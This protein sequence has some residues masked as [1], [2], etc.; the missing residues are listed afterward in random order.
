MKTIYYNGIV[1]TGDMPP[2]SGFAVENGKFTAVGSDESLLK[3]RC[4][5]DILIDLQG[6]FVCAGFND[7]HMHLLNYGYALTMAPLHRHTRSLSDMLDCLRSFLAENP[8]RPGDYLLG[9]GWN[10]DYFEDEHRLPTKEDLDSVS[11]D[12]PI[13]I[14]RACGHIGCA[15]TAAI[16]M[17]GV[18][19]TTPQPD[20]GHFD[21]V[22]GELTGIFRE[23]ALSMVK[24]PIPQPDAE[25]IADMIRTAAKALN[26]YGIT[27]C[28]T[29]DFCVFPDVSPETIHAAY[30]RL[31]DADDLTVRVYE[32]AHFCD[33]ESLSRYI[34]AGHTTGEGDDFFRVGPLK[35]L[36]D[37]S[38]GAGTAYLS[39]PYADQPD[40]RGIAIY[41]PEQFHAM[42]SLA[43]NSDMQ[44]AIHAIGDGILDDILD[45]YEDV[46]TKNPRDDHRHG[47]VHCQI[48]RPDQLTRMKDLRLHAYVQSIFLDYDNRIVRQRV[49]DLADSSY[50]FRT[51]KEQYHASNGSDCPVELPNVLGGIQCGVTRNTLSGDALY[52]PEE[53]FSV[54]QAIDS[55]TCEGAF[56]SFEE[57][58]KG[59]IRPGMLADFVVL[60]TS[61]FDTPANKIADIPVLQTVLGGKCVYQK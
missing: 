60:G 3:T 53:A 24:A 2:V 40:N 57:N 12:V 25:A 27:S 10:H 19:P 37:G 34:A 32:Q 9:R 5:G 6:K 23:N 42:I 50:A 59:K 45:A 29:D 15:N 21:I 36:G 20:G 47:V 22:N 13:I 4:D 49:G 39:R 46:L 30:R 11:R 54:Q 28:Q 38:L 16:H 61:P 58:V 8:P 17:A 41:T 31:S 51:L 18:T 55:F 1:Y 52:R 48:T 7:S 43:H 35:L 33:T 44:V 14:T 26:A 56:A